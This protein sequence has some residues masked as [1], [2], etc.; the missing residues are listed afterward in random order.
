MRQLRP[1]AGWCVKYFSTLLCIDWIHPDAPAELRLRGHHAM[2]ALGLSSL[3][4]A[5]QEWKLQTLAL[6]GYKP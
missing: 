4:A 6:A 2:E 5:A 3:D 1:I